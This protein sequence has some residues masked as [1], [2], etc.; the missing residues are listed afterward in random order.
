M[1]RDLAIEL[2]RRQ[3]DLVEVR[4]AAEM[5]A[6]RHH[7]QAE[8]FEQRIGQVGGRIGD[9]GD[10]SRAHVVRGAA[11]R[12]HVV[13]LL[14]ADRAELRDEF[15]Q[16]LGIVRVDVHAQLAARAADDE[17]G[18]ECA[19]ALAHTAWIERGAGDH[20]LGAVAVA[21]VAR[22]AVDHLLVATVQRSR[23]DL[24]LAAREPRAH[25]FQQVDET[26][27]AGIDDSRSACFLEHALRARERPLQRLHDGREQQAEIGRLHLADEALDL[28]RE[29][30]QYRQQRALTRLRQRVA[31]VGSAGAHGLCEARR[32]EAL[33]MS[34]AIAEPEQELSEDRA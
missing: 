3:R 4:A 8:R 30:R 1:P 33:Q 9:D 23:D 19:Q 34:G 2:V 11:L 22:A 12:L 31:G 32:I 14:R 26:L 27:R 20:A 15:E 25:A 6:H 21:R 24:H 29:I 13:G 7:V 17:A 28:T 10:A 18:A 5:H 16:L